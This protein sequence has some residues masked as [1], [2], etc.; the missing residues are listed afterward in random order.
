MP[1]CEQECLRGRWSIAA[2]GSQS[3]N[4]IAHFALAFSRKESVCVGKAGGGPDERASH[5]CLSGW[6]TLAESPCH[7]VDQWYA[8]SV[9]NLLARA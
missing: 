3:S 2:G 1:G 9:R 7:T 5:C 6:A 4:T 8:K